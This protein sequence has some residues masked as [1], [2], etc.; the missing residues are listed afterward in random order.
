[1]DI[2]PDL[3]DQHPSQLQL[4]SSHWEHY[5]ALCYFSGPA[6][7][8][9]CFEDNSRIKE[10]LASPGEGR[11]L[12]VNGQGSTQRALIGDMI[13]QSGIDNNWGGVIIYGAIRDVHTLSQ[14]PIGIKAL[15]A[16][17]I[18]SQREGKGEIEQEIVVDR[19]LIKPGN[20]IYADLNG[21]AM[22][23]H[24]LELA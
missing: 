7:T 9:N 19:T 1:M 10:L 17:P 12:V 20:Y 22:S 14:M 4:V 6:V 3:F 11:I 15:C 24:K 8:V 23:E 21:V 2:L 18:R 13:A 5:G 16:C